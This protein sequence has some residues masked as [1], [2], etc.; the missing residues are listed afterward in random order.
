MDLT[1]PSPS[2]QESDVAFLGPDLVRT[3][4]IGG[5]EFDGFEGFDAFHAGI[6]QEPTSSIL[7]LRALDDA[8]EGTAPHKYAAFELEKVL[9]MLL[10]QSPLAL[11]I[12]TSPVLTSTPVWEPPELEALVNDAV[13]RRMV[14]NFVSM[15][16]SALDRHASS[17][18]RAHVWALEA[19][20]WGLAA[21]ALTDGIVEFELDRLT[22]HYEL[23]IDGLE[24]E[25]LCQRANES[26]ELALKSSSRLPEGPRGYD[27]LSTWLIDRRR[28]AF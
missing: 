2:L 19:L 7:G 17:T 6:W 15:S 1:L 25:A 5:A 11:Q 24:S 26:G 16:Q 10:R 13:S 22:G 8:R 3:C 9:R 28:E 20:R 12:F 23:T 27:Q 18:N 21:R 4:L 14:D